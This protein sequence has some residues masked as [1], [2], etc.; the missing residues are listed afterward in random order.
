MATADQCIKQG[1]L[2]AA[3]EIYQ[4][5]LTTNSGLLE[6]KQRLNEVNDL[7]LKKLMDSK[8]ADDSGQLSPFLLSPKP[9]EKKTNTNY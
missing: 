8:D 3:I 7:Y 5:L 2:K 6:I 1:L 9:V 4:Q